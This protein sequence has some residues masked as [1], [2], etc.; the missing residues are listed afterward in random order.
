MLAKAVDAIGDTFALYGFS[1]RGKDAVDFYIMKDFD[2]P[3]SRAIDHRIA[4][5]E[6][7]IQNRDGAAIRHAAFKLSAQTAKIKTLILISDGK[8]LDDGYR[9]SY[10]MADTKMALR[11]AKQRGIHPYCITVDREGAEYLKGMYGEVAYMVID[12]V[13]R[14][15]IRL[16]QIYKSL[17]T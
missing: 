5:I 14:L 2:E 13:D 15:P 1:G 6:A 11:E 12:R 9:G 17:T 4:H 10:A 16:P 8:P 3:Y 7:A